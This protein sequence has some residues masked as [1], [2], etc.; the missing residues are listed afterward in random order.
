MKVDWKMTGYYPVSAKSVYEELETLG[1]EYT[2]RDVVELARNENTALHRCF[3]W[4]DTI[5]AEKYREVQARQVLRMLVFVDEEKDEKTPIRVIQAKPDERLV[6]T[7]TRLIMQD[8]TEYEKLLERAMAEL[9][10]FKEKYQC[11]KELDY[12]LKLIK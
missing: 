1:D 4:D 10:A 7:P 11:L 6:Y 12:I 3:E 9:Q 8:K 5:A 2:P